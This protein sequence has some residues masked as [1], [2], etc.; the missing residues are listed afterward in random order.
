[1]GYSVLS[2]LFC[3]KPKITQKKKKNL[4]IRRSTGGQSRRSQRDPGTARVTGAEGRHVW[5][6]GDSQAVVLY[7]TASSSNRAKSPGLGKQ[8]SILGIKHALIVIAQNELKSK[9]MLEQRL[10]Q[11]EHMTLPPQVSMTSCSRPQLRLSRVQ[12]PGTPRE[13]LYQLPRIF[14]KVKSYY[15]FNG[16]GMQSKGSPRAIR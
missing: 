4:F 13:M 15:A 2:T 14:I 6:A 10:Y 9:S 1:M 5:A 8:N 12:F 16:E 7:T 3:C 11:Q